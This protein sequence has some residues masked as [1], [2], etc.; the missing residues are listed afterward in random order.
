MSPLQYTNANL[1][2]SPQEKGAHIYEGMTH[3]VIYI[4]MESLCQKYKVSIFNLP[5][6]ETTVV[7]NWL[8][9]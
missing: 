2:K 5:L 6:Y 9:Y 8:T 1:I 4:C 3:Q 7:Q